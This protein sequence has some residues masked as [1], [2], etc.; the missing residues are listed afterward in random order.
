MKHNPEA[1]CIAA[2]L[3][4]LC[5]PVSTGGHYDTPNIFNNQTAV[6]S[7]ANPT[8]GTYIPGNCN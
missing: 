8:P 7:S 5:P 1:V 3:R 4:F 6:K 2:E